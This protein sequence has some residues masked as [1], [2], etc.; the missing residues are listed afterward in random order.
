[1]I[2]ISYYY[3]IITINIITE[4]VSA[5]MDQILS[6]LKIFILAVGWRMD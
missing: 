2:I 1:M 5:G 4:E 6:Y 3:I